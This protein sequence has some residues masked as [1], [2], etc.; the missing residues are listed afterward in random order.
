MGVRRDGA[1]RLPH[2]INQVDER[3]SK[4]RVRGVGQNGRQYA[5]TK[6]CCVA[7]EFLPNVRVAR[8]RVD[9][10]PTVGRNACK[11]LYAESNAIHTHSSN[12]I[13][14]TDHDRV[15]NTIV[16]TV[17]TPAHRSLHAIRARVEK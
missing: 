12:G 9:I 8:S 5:T 7:Y 1:D 11:R 14:D 4:E 17:V 2:S 3:S 6:R 13:V 10:L 15:A 16:K